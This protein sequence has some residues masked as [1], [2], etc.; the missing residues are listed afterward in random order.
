MLILPAFLLALVPAIVI[1]YP[2]LRGACEADLLEDESSPRAELDRRWDA[3]VAGI[4]N[5]E[6]ERGIGN[7]TEDDYRTLRRQYTLE[8]ASVMR[9]MELEEEQ[10]AELLETIARELGQARLPIAESGD[11]ESA[12]ACPHCLAPLDGEPD[13]C[14]SCGR[15]VKSADGGGSR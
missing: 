10:E 6:L 7:L 1:I 8:A 14:T 11:A 5:T 9:S 4:K 2:F 15:Q 13:R 3:I 12:P